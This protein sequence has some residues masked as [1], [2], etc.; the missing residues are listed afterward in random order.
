MVKVNKEYEPI[1]KNVEIYDELYEIY[2]KLYSSFEDNKIFEMI[3]KFQL[4]F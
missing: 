1:A 4:K 3:A 2:C